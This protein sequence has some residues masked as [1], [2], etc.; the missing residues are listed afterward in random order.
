MVA[1][2]TEKPLGGKEGAIVT[3]STN[4]HLQQRIISL[5]FADTY[6]KTGKDDY[7]PTCLF[8]S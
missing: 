3:G 2:Q 6:L 7:N 8:S 1:N 4:E 5:T